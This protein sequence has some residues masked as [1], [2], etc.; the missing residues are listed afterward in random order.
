MHLLRQTYHQTQVLI[1][2]SRE[3][4][5]FF[6]ALE[7]EDVVYLPNP[8]RENFL[9]CH[10]SPSINERI[11]IGF[12]GQ[13]KEYK[14]VRLLPYVAEHFPDAELH[15][16]G[17]GPLHKWLMDE[18]VKHSNLIFDGY[19]PPNE[20]M[21]KYVGSLD[22]VLVPSICCE[23]CPSVVLE[24]FALRKPVVSFDLGGQAELI[25]F[26]K[27]GLLAQPFDTRE[28]VEKIN[29]LISDPRKR[30][31]FGS[32]GRAWIEDRSQYRRFADFLI[33]IYDSM[34]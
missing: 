27:G 16:A 12:I 14:G 24:A 11:K 21:I 2:I 33:R 32:K 25:R 8:V 18:S 13:L 28:F 10:R 20:Y 1:S 15:V 9:K 31:Y 30:A 26:A 34:C 3:L 7:Y 6:R 17:W 22:V 29:E 4:Y 19:I 23:A 5:G